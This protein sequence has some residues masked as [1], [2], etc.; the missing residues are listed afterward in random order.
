MT[1]VNISTDGGEGKRIDSAL[2]DCFMKEMV[3]PAKERAGTK[4]L[5]LTTLQTYSAMGKA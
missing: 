1:E 2:K 5:K 4:Q 3:F